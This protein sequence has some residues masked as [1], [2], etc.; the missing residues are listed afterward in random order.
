MQLT[1]IIVIVCC[2]VGVV[3]GYPP[4]ANNIYMQ[5]ALGRS[6]VGD[7]GMFCVVHVH[8]FFI[9]F[10]SSLNKCLCAVELTPTAIQARDTPV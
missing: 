4:Y 5:M 8:V 7:V 9:S 6:K 1:S 10:Y 2:G 3:W